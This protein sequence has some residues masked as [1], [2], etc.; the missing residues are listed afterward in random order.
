MLSLESP[1]RGDSNQ[2]TQYTI[3]NM[4]TKTPK[5]IRNLQL[6]DF[7]KGLK[8]KFETAMINEPSVF[9][10]LKFYCIF[11]PTFL[12]VLGKYL[13][14][15]SVICSVFFSALHWSTSYDSG[16]LRQHLGIT[17]DFIGDHQSANLV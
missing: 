3:F 15:V 7:S 14:M 13:V 12:S 16:I 2:Y 9:E 5:I 6:W 1:H 17:R 4:E 11:S 8:N 10:P